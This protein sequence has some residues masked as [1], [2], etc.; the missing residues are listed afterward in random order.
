MAAHGQRGGVATDYVHVTHAARSSGRN[1]NIS[2]ET[3]HVNAGLATEN[4]GA[5]AAN[6][7]SLHDPVP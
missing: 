1:G 6:V 5:H 7:P 3:Q 2:M 4:T